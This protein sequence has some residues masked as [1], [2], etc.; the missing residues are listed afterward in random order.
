MRSNADEPRRTLEEV[1]LMEVS[2]VTF[3]ANDK[4][5]VLGVKNEITIRTAERALREAGFS[6]R[7]QANHR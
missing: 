6:Q 7:S 3:P 2:L 4:A 1:R 5:R